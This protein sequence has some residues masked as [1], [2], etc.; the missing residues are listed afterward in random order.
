M[1]ALKDAQRKLRTTTSKAKEAADA[2]QG[3]T[4]PDDR[5]LKEELE[6]L[7]EQALD[8]YQ[9]AAVLK[10]RVGPENTAG[11]ERPSGSATTRASRP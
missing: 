10:L 5:Q 7:R 1:A 6:V 3:A 9:Q 2:A 8:L 11:D 4:D